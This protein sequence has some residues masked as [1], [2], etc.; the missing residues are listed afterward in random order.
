MEWLLANWLSLL[1]AIFAFGLVVFVHESGHFL[2]ARAVG[3]RV[4]EF[5]LGFGPQ[6]WKRQSGE[7]EYSIR[8][9]PL[10]GFV[11][12]EGEDSTDVR[13]DDPGNFQNKTSLQKLAVIVGGCLMNYS[14]A[15]IVFLLLGMLHGLPD[16]GTRISMVQP[17]MPASAA[18]L[19]P[20]DVVVAIDGQKV[21]DWEDM[22]DKISSHAGVPIKLTI[23]RGDSTL[24]LPITPKAVD[25]PDG[26]ERKPVGR[27]GVAVDQS[28][29][30]L[31]F[32]PPTGGIAQ[33]AGNYWSRA[34]SLT[35]QPIMLVH[36]I[37]VGKQKASEVASQMSGPVMIGSFFVEAAAK[38]FW[39]L[40]FIWTIISTLVGGFNLL[41]IPALDGAR[42]L[43][44]L[45][46]AIRRKPVDQEKEAMFHTVG[47]ALLLT[48]VVV[49]TFHDIIKLR[50]GFHLLQ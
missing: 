5:S 49:I 34:I 38:G 6:L 25:V 33:V 3:V 17:S 15:F 50:S 10:G 12:L 4:H 11:R 14:S 8:A 28:P 16:T 48:L 22:T 39:Y 1:A 29:A 31:V 35:L 43:I 40:A 23:Q 13:P 44:V 41:P 9:V 30:N 24:E 32:V 18:G 27:I 42:G 26:G 21:T 45:I 37:F 47:L 20:K 19:Q 2:I 46:G 36:D 7:T